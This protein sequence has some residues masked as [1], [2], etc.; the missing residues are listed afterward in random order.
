MD[1]LPPAGAP[2]R[3]RA[4]GRSASPRPTR[5]NPGEVWEEDE[6]WI[7]LSWRI[8]PDGS[9]G[10]RKYFESPYRPGEKITVDE[11]YGWMFENSVPGPAGGGGE[12]GADAA[13]V[14]AQV[15]RVPGRRTEST[16]LHETTLEAAIDRR[17]RARSIRADR[18]RSR[19]AGA[20]VGVEVDGTARVGFPTP[21][22]KL[23][24]YSPTLRRLG[25]A[26]VR[27][28]GLHPEPRPLDARST[29]QT[30]EFVLL[31]T[32]RLPTLIHTRSGNAKW[33]YEIS[34][35]NPLWIH[36]RTPR[37]SASRPATSC[38]VHT[39]DRLLRG[40]G[41]GDRGDPPGRRRV[42]AP[43][44]PLAAR[45][46]QG[47]EPLVHRARATSS[48]RGPAS[49]G[50][51]SSHGIRPVRER[52]PRHRSAIWWDDA[53]VHQN[54]TFPVQPDPVSGMHC[55]HQKVTRR[56]AAARTTATATSSST[57]RSRTRCTAAGSRWRARAP[58]PGEL[59]RPLWLPRAYK[60]DPASYRMEA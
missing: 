57:R 32:F 50:C 13:R 51:G 5:R 26:G 15:R 30:N 9:L 52:G 46:E 60:P 20:A 10:I 55:W 8:D 12:G 31:P 16:A 48:S 36:P 19:K 44:G 53:G 29:A 28:A 47:G 35:T 43:P 23:E 4:R 42:L 49:G 27:A 59:R 7:E 58:G 24:F 14:H 34:H 33:L 18:R 25:L 22:R 41:L 1:R 11:Y 37:G 21:S 39:R 3:A 17:R 45:E 38:K 6:F 40:Q 2:R 56:A 54:L